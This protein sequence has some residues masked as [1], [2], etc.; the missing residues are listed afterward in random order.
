MDKYQISKRKLA[1]LRRNLERRE[2]RL[3]EQQEIIRIRQKVKKIIFYSL[4]S[5]LV[6]FTAYFIL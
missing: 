4:I 2:K 1:Q 6:I 3:K 5:A